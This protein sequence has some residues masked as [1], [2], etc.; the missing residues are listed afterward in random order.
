MKNKRS[1]FNFIFKAIAIVLIQAFLVMD[2]AWAA[3]GM[4]FSNNHTQTETLAPKLQLQ[5]EY[6]QTFFTT[7]NSNDKLEQLATA[8]LE[9]ASDDTIAA[10]PVLARLITFFTRQVVRFQRNLK[11]FSGAAT[12][13]FGVLGLPGLGDFIVNNSWAGDLAGKYNFEVIASSSIIGLAVGIVVAAGAFA[14]VIISERR[15]K[16]IFSNSRQKVSEYFKDSF[17]LLMVLFIF[18][19][20]FVSTTMLS[21]KLKGWVYTDAYK[22]VMAEERGQAIQRQMQA[23]TQTHRDL[24]KEYLEIFNLIDN[25]EHSSWAGYKT[26]PVLEK[27]QSFNLYNLLNSKNGSAK[28]FEP[29]AQ[30][31]GDSDTLD[32]DFTGLVF[33]ETGEVDVIGSENERK[34]QHRLYFDQSNG[35]ATGMIIG[36]MLGP[37]AGVSRST[38]AL[39]GMVAG[40][41][42]K[43]EGFKMNF[44]S[45]LSNARSSR[46]LKKIT[47]VI[48]FETLQ[49]IANSQSS[50]K[51]D[52]SGAP[53]KKLSSLTSRI[54]S[55]V[56]AGIL[57][58]MLVFPFAKPAMS[59][60]IQAQAP[61]AVVQTLPADLQTLHGDTRSLLNV[62]S[63]ANDQS[64]F[65]ESQT[66]ELKT[67]IAKDGLSFTNPLAEKR[68]DQINN[69]LEQEWERLSKSGEL[70]DYI[71]RT[72][73]SPE[74]DAV[75]KMKLLIQ[76]ANPSSYEIIKSRNA[77]IYVGDIP[78][79]AFTTGSRL[80]GAMGKPLIYINNDLI[81][82]IFWAAYA[83]NHE[84]IHAGDL[85]EG[86]FGVAMQYNIVTFLHS[87]LFSAS[88][89]TEAKAY[90]AEAKFTSKF[91]IVPEQGDRYVGEL[92]LI[93]PY[94]HQ[95]WMR[96]EFTLMGTI[97][98]NLA[99]LFAAIGI[100]RF[101]R[102]RK[103]RN[104]NY[105]GLRRRTLTNSKKFKTNTR[106]SSN[107]KNDFRL[108]RKNKKRKGNHFWSIVPTLLT[109]G[110]LGAL[111]AEPAAAQ[112]F[113]DALA[114]GDASFLVMAGIV[115]TALSAMTV[116]WVFRIWGMRNRAAEQENQAIVPSN[117]ALD[118]IKELEKQISGLL[119]QGKEQVIVA[120]D[121]PSGA[122]KT[123][124]A[125]YIQSQGIAGID[126][127]QIQ[128]LSRDDYT[129]G[130]NYG[131]GNVTILEKAW[132]RGKL[133][134]VE[135]NGIQWAA[136]TL[137]KDPDTAIF[138]ADPDILIKVTA[139]YELRKKRLENKGMSSSDVND[140]L[141]AS[142]PSDIDPV[143]GENIFD[144]VINQPYNGTGTGK[145]YQAYEKLYGKLKTYDNPKL[146][147]SKDFVMQVITDPTSRARLI[148]YHNIRHFNELFG[149]VDSLQEYVPFQSPEKAVL[150][151]RAAIYMHDLGY[152]NS[153]D[154]YL[155]LNHEKRSIEKFKEFLEANPGVFNRQEAQAIIYM[156]DMTQ[157]KDRT[158]E[159]FK[160]MVKRDNRVYD[161]LAKMEAQPDSELEQ[162]IIQEVEDYF[163]EKFPGS[164]YLDPENRKFVMDIII[165]GK[166][167]A[168]ADLWGG[169]E[170]YL[171]M[172]ALL[173][174]E[175][176]YDKE[177]GD[178]ASPA[179]QTD[180]EQAA[181]SSGFQEFF[182]M[183]QR[184]VFLLKDDEF[185]SLGMQQYIDAQSKAQKDSGNEYAS[186]NL[187]R[188]S[189]LDESRFLKN[190]IDEIISGFDSQG[191]ALD[192]YKN[193]N[194]LPQVVALMNF[195]DRG[196]EAG[197]Y[198]E[199][200]R[201][202]LILEINGKNGLI[203]RGLDNQF[204]IPFD[205]VLPEDLLPTLD[206]ALM[207][208]RLKSILNPQEQ[209]QL[210]DAVEIKEFA[211]GEVIMEQGIA[212]EKGVF[213]VVHGEP[214]IF[215]N[216]YRIGQTKTGDWLGEMAVVSDAPRS[217]TVR[218]PRNAARPVKLAQIP[219][220]FFR[221]LLAGNGELQGSISQIIEQRQQRT[222]ELLQEEEAKDGETSLKDKF[223][224]DLLD[225]VVFVDVDLMRLTNQYVAK[226]NVNFLL[227]VL[228]NEFGKVIKD[229]GAENAVSLRR[230]GDEFILALDTSGNKQ[231]AKNIA[232]KLKDNVQ[233]TRF[234]IA[235]IG[236]DK[237]SEE[238]IAIIQKL[239]GGI[240]TLGR[241][242]VIIAPQEKGGLRGRARAQEF[243]NTV[244]AMIRFSS[245]YKD[246]S[247]SGFLT[248]KRS[249]L[250]RKAVG[251]EV[252][253]TLS[254][255]IA[256][257]FETEEN[258]AEGFN[259]YEK[260]RNLAAQR[261]DKSKETF[262]KLGNG[263]IEAEAA[264]TRSGASGESILL[265]DKANADYLVFENIQKAANRLEG[266]G[267]L[268]GM[269]HEI[270]PEVTYFSTENALRTRLNQMMQNQE[271]NGAVAFS[272]Q[273]LGYYDEA[274]KIDK[275][276]TEYYDSPGAVKDNRIDIRDFK[277]VNEAFGYVAGDQV[278]GRMRF[279]AISS[280]RIFED[281]EVILARGPPAGP[282][283]LLIP[284][285]EKAMQMTAQEKQDL[286][287]EY[288]Q[289]VAEY[290]NQTGQTEVKAGQFRIVWDEVQPADKDIG[291]VMERIS[292]TRAVYEYLQEPQAGNKKVIKYENSIEESWIT[293]EETN[294]IDAVEQLAQLKADWEANMDEQDLF[295]SNRQ[296]SG[297]LTVSRADG[298]QWQQNSYLVDLVKSFSGTSLTITNEQ[299][300]Q[301]TING[302][303][304][305]FNLQELEVKGGQTIMLNIESPN[306]QE[307]LD[308]VIAVSR[309]QD[310]TSYAAGDFQ[311]TTDTLL[312]FETI[313]VEETLNPELKGNSFSLQDGR[314]DQESLNLSSLEQSI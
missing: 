22:K 146:N 222:N 252:S 5:T 42:F 208:S 311:K 259:K 250:N 173:G 105:P 10:E 9:T 31:Y 113:A 145:D 195:I 286:F 16:D 87:W 68:V 46:G 132:L 235:S 67:W 177:Q 174:E 218:V 80:A 59:Q 43:N 199:A 128:V 151:L 291:A 247:E 209:Q 39:G 99:P 114:A 122:G 111:N 166:L 226:K 302:S 23:V 81:S 41:L 33:Y 197:I 156:I 13:F 137:Q 241:Q 73:G 256:N 180:L 123:T 159:P 161:A 280:A 129:I 34:H 138:Y 56:V 61:P 272:L 48:P 279:G 136:D 115:V 94:Y 289:Q 264:F 294:A 281:F 229:L 15:S 178:S 306:A 236:T 283:G 6:I 196:V 312:D 267:K 57:L 26:D 63:L 103:D 248:I 255:G 108:I 125:R 175:F 140:R 225:T 116:K 223:E 95:R 157:M 214:D 221:K 301:V 233:N 40:S 187:K 84:A 54:K 293:L 109:T 193:T 205:A 36:Y 192:F 143:T 284:K 107:I 249:W 60:T 50:G 200:D 119:D 212:D 100:F 305:L 163:N 186:L 203:Y 170:G 35:A 273:A 296:I 66:G 295:I 55:T 254:I 64:P 198:S 246:Q 266:E 176:R 62:V 230:G 227:S 189:M 152:F 245:E 12:T 313:W 172:V 82:N 91:N 117:A 201:Q 88:D 243:I 160:Q 58:I 30:A 307:V 148:G 77:S 168:L 261:K 24:A 29:L 167:I 207:I 220:E 124:I 141:Q 288:M 20:S 275:Y 52:K 269:R 298:L 149:F 274:G 134:I 65:K 190:S 147:I 290:F 314:I 90:K 8:T 251:N 268:T 224:Q 102:N 110:L 257:A 219:A 240:D 300:R 74:G 75:A 45:D 72:M 126:P 182:A 204:N 19:V 191:N 135:G 37:S 211:P 104:S 154:N 47:G 120:I 183:P 79:A 164:S 44:L 206:D 51:S 238:A 228:E 299:G 217:A 184:L 11:V 38:G 133:V 213:L 27:L 144:I 297:R 231:L 244:N 188:E 86:I 242:Y 97:I 185:P 112:G 3:A 278:I 89:P 118:K 85:P 194:E 49:K 76:I 18:A 53:A 310:P 4:D 17:F 21:L 14:Y 131:E 277:V 142:D 83:L 260:T 287:F 253:F 276:R 169:E 96:I 262:K 181:E 271:L 158:G 303:G 28:I 216:G 101:F 70:D 258:G 165:A 153:E 308:G 127:S 304:D 309:G 98:F 202:K 210:E 32:N 130:T 285:T 179:A 25:T 139:P 71:A 155:S 106:I 2:I 239:G 92:D 1:K 69:W 171:N 7:I 121:G 292:K 263:H 150:L 93:A 237:P 215:I 270:A 282:N 232:V 234:S 162:Q 78:G 265:T